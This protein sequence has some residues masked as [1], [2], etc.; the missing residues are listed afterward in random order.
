MNCNP[1]ALATAIASLLH[2]ASIYIKN[3]NIES[4]EKFNNNQL[5][6]KLIKVLINLSS[7]KLLIKQQTCVYVRVKFKKFKLD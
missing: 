1:A 2:P 6:S 3:N 5:T 7:L 4:I